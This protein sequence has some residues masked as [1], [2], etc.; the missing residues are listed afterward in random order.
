MEADKLL[1][2]ITPEEIHPSEASLIR[3]VLLEDSKTRVHLRHPKATDEQVAAII[4]EIPRELW[5]RIS[6][7]DRQEVAANHPGAGVHLTHRHPTLEVSLPEGVS[8]SASCH[9]A[10]EVLASPAELSY[11][12]LSPVFDSISKKGYTSG[13]DLTAP[14]VREALGERRV[15]ALG[16]MTPERLKDVW[17]TGF[18]GAAFLGYVWEDEE[19]AARWHEIF[20]AIRP[21]MSWLQFITDAPDI[22]QTVRQARQAVAGGCRWVQVRM[23]DAPERD[24]D[25]ALLE[26]YDFCH[27]NGATL[28]V[29]DNV[30][31]A[32]RCHIDGVHLGRNDM[33]PHRARKILGE[34][35]L[36]GAT[37]NCLED[38]RRIEGAPIDYIGLGPWRYT[39][40]K[41]VGLAEPLGADGTRPLVR[42]IRRA[43]IRVPVLAIGG[44]T[45][46]DVAMVM[47]TEVDGIAIS[48]A[49][50]RADDPVAAAHTF[51]EKIHATNEK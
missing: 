18:Y 51:I 46:D 39:T 50:A 29:D 2:L 43:G 28:I 42:E 49:I 23:K 26:L 15:I 38:I 30:E 4:D 40:T 19:P 3:S 16:G 22:E 13:F 14:E 27:D 31:A 44:I 1:I 33:S 32:G 41:R 11:V 6:I 20:D 10:A 36:I 35:A 47:S 17:Q 25:A 21:Q 12:F 37:V 8:L 5:N 7:H 9:S 48:G 34:R 24:I 45:I